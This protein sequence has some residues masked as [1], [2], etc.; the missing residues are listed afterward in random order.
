MDIAMVWPLWLDKSKEFSWEV[1]LRT[2]HGFPCV[3]ST[4]VKEHQIVLF[5][6]GLSL[7]SSSWL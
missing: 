2:K 3:N 6:P 4:F 1:L 5:I 7:V